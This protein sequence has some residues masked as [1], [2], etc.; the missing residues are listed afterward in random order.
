MP[1][2]ALSPP[3]SKR[4]PPQGCGGQVEGPNGC[5]NQHLKI[6]DV[7]YV[8]NDYVRWTGL[9]GFVVRGTYKSDHIT[10]DFGQPDADGSFVIQSHGRNLFMAVIYSTLRLE[11]VSI[12]ECGSLANC[13]WRFPGTP[14]VHSGY[15]QISLWD[16]E[17]CLSVPSV[18]DLSR[19]LVVSGCSVRPD[20]S[21]MFYLD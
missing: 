18:T 15:T 6:S 9:D 4:A 2:F 11:M 1:I 8:P 21:Q 20:P 5:L 10:W 7:K 12:E 16:E 19:E 14:S 13:W 3:P 17:K